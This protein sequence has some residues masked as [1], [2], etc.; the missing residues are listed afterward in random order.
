MGVMWSAAYT[1]I[2]GLLFF[3]HSYFLGGVVAPTSGLSGLLNSYAAGL[4][5]DWGWSPHLHGPL[6]FC[7]LSPFGALLFG[8][9][10]YFV[11]D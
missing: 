8:G 3:C 11:L 2:M 5:L 7:V 10:M 9:G 1:V 4:L 6:T